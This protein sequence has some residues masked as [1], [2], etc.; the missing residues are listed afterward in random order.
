MKHIRDKKF[1]LIGVKPRIDT[2]LPL[3][4]EQ[5]LLNKKR[6]IIEA[7]LKR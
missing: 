3:T 7:H 6:V 5:K 4:K 2:N 1:E